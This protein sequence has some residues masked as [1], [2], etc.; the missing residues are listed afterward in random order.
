MKSEL[1]NDGGKEPLT[2]AVVQKSKPESLLNSPGKGPLLNEPDKESLLNTPGKIPAANSPE[3]NDE[4]GTTGKIFYRE[5]LIR[6]FYKRGE[7]I[8]ARPDDIVM[9]ESSDHLINIYIV[10]EDKIKKTIRSNSLKDF[11]A[12]LPGTQFLRIGRFCVINLKRLSG[13]N[14]K[15]QTFEFD[16]KVSIKLKHAIPPSWFNDIGK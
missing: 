1:K 11:L 12:Q 4:P 10:H 13:G 7:F 16:F 5:N 15:E 6:L 3:K 14:C 9:V 2:K 8:Y